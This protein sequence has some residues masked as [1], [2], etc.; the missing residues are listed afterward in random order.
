[1]IRCKTEKTVIVFLTCTFDPTGP[2]SHISRK[3]W[4]WSHSSVSLCLPRHGSQPNVSSGRLPSWNTHHKAHR[5]SLGSSC[6]LGQF[7]GFYFR[8]TKS[9]VFLTNAQL[10]FTSVSFG[11]LK[12]VLVSV[13]CDPPCGR[14]CD[15][16]DGTNSES[17]CRTGHIC[18]WK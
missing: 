1:M 10:R 9:R 11:R 14:V 15:H 2:P 12:N 7:P 16:G 6:S 5:E 4:S 8:K 18:A 13:P 3:F 17:P